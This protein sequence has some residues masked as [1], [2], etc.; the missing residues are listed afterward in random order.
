MA[1]L[2]LLEKEQI[3]LSATT[4]TDIHTCATGRAEKVAVFLCN[5]SGA[6]TLRL[7]VAIA[8][9]TDSLSQ[10]LYYDTVLPANDTL[11][12]ELTLNSGDVVRA[13]AGAAT[14]SASVFVDESLRLAD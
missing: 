1:E 10:Y 4:L 14:V 12:V 13:Y 3:A 6:T 8:G 9:A 11:Q 7:A 5:R 2:G